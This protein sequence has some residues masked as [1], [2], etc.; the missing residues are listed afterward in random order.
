MAAYLGE[1]LQS[2]TL[3]EPSI[4]EQ[5]IK[6][7]FADTK[8]VSIASFMLSHNMNSFRAEFDGITSTWGLVLNEYLDSIFSQQIHE[9]IKVYKHYMQ[10]TLID[11]VFLSSTD[12]TFGEDYWKST[13]SNLNKHRGAALAETLPHINEVF[14]FPGKVLFHFFARV[15]GNK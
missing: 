10:H 15:K 3:L 14:W 12:I 2:P 9:N 1:I 4:V 13:D 7:K 11:T 6:G 8:S 5:T